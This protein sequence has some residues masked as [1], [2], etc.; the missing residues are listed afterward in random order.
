M[1]R[2]GKNSEGPDH[3]GVKRHQDLSIDLRHG[4]QEQAAQC[5]AVPR[6]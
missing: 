1:R 2:C 4:D 5:G 6:R 3:L